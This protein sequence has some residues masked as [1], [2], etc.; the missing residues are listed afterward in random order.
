[1]AELATIVRNTC[2]APNAESD[3]L[4]LGTSQRTKINT[5]AAAAKS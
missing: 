5:T 3:Q 2:R 4:M 1:M